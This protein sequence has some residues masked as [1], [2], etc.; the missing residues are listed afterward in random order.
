MDGLGS[1]RVDVKIITK[2]QCTECLTLHRDKYGA[3]DCCQPSICEVFICPDCGKAHDEE[4]GA[5]ECCNN[6]SP[7]AV[8]ARAIALEKHGQQRLIA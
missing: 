4:I 7:A 3:G 1:E 5:I 8:T 6:D 2:W